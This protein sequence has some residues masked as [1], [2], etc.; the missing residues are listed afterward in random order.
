MKNVSRRM[1][2]KKGISMLLALVLVLSLLPVAALADEAAPAQIDGVYQIGTPQELLWF[3]NKVNSGSRDLK[4]ALTA[5]I[6]MTGQDMTGQQWPGIGTSN[7]RF[8]GTFN[9]NNHVVTLK[10]T[11]WGLFGFVKGSEYISGATTYPVAEIRN[12]VVAGTVRN[13]AVVQN[14]INAHISGCINRAT[15]SNAGSSCIGGIVGSSGY[16]QNGNSFQND[17]LI[18]NCGNEASISG[19]EYIAGI[20]GEASEVNTR[21]VG[22]YNTGNIHGNRYI[23]GIAGWTK[24][25]VG[26]GLVEN[27]YNTGRVT[28]STYVAGIVGYMANG[29]AVRNC[30][31]TGNT[32][33]AITGGRYN[34]TA[35]I[36][37]SYFLGTNSAKVSPDYIE[38]PTYND[39]TNEIQSRAAA[40]SGPEMSSVEFAQLLGSAFQASCPSAVLTWQTASGHTGEVCENCGLGSVE[41]EVY[42]ISFSTGDGYTLVGDDHV[43]RGSAY[44][45]YLELTDGFWKN[46][47]TF[48][49][50]VNGVEVGAATDGSFTV[51][52]VTG[53]L[54]ITVT[55]VEAI[56]GSF[57]VKLPPEG[58]GY[59]IQGE[60]TVAL[61]EDY[62][63]SISFLN[64]FSEGDDFAVTAREVVQAD[65]IPEIRTL[66]KNGD[67]NY[68]ITNVQKTYEI[69][70]SGVKVTPTVDPVTVTFTVSEGYNNF[71]VAPNSGTAM[72]DVTLTVPYFDLSL[73]GLERYYYNPTCYMDGDVIQSVQKAGTPEI[74]YNH[75]TVMHAF[76]AATEVFRLKY[77]PSKVGTGESYKQDPTRFSN[78]NPNAA[79]SWTQ[80]PGSSFMD[81]WEHG[82]NMNYYVNYTYPLGAPAW[83]STSDQIEIHDGDDITLHLITGPGSG[84]RFGVFTVNDTNAKFQQTAI[85]DEYTVDQGQKLTLT[86]YWTNTTGNYTTRYDKMAGQQL[87]WAPYGYH[88][89]DV[90][91]W[92]RTPFGQ[93]P[94][95]VDPDSGEEMEPIQTSAM[96]TDAN[97]RVTINTAGIEPGVYY[98]A[99]LGGFTAGGGADQAGF[100]ST[101]AEAGVSYFKLTIREYNG[102]T[103]DINNDT[104]I[105]STDAVL[106]LRYAAGMNVELNEAIADVNGDGKVNSTDAVL[107]LRY[108]A[109][110][111]TEFPVDKKAE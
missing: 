48:S 38:I 67:G 9:G 77:D 24:G 49:L 91:Q 102:K 61:G 96:V 97:G 45:F 40:K 57:A 84:S 18:E 85:R 72:M 101:G 80:G 29:T 5:D 43:T 104:R 86:L 103:G 52:N 70:V 1:N 41:K 105:N 59:R 47:H 98:I 22:C 63:F 95:A 51:L 73:Y 3:A 88:V 8:S 108:A 89:P 110:T 44:T 107:V 12:V 19:N 31:N 56:P 74:A 26:T 78:E 82:T 106:M 83:G 13:S 42:D 6:D 7:S 33:Y 53:P 10:D 100:V 81:F 111:L 37:N 32:T 58:Y 46:G 54:S 99:A 4:G 30:F 34:H 39:T 2:M 23:G 25:Y 28:G 17:L 55:G 50:K 79:V 15:I 36:V 16:N 20:I 65:Q 69:L 93:M 62:V 92:F 14:A 64:G 27:C 109:G 68:V 87:L 94:E 71:H 90:S 21:I 11:T 60:K 35:N 76:I 66:T 75:I